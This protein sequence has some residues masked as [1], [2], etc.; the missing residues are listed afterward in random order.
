MI[1]NAADVTTVHL[2]I[3]IVTAEMTDVTTAGM[4]DVTTA[5]TTDMMN[6]GTTDVMTAGTDVTVTTTGLGNIKGAAS[7]APHDN[8]TFQT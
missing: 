8:T 3:A 5:E 1:M 2:A 4:T 6:A 7:A